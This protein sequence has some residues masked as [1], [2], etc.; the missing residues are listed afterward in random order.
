[1]EEF[2]KL[3][4]AAI[5]TIDILL[6]FT[7]EKMKTQIRLSPGS[8]VAI[9]RYLKENYSTRV[10]EG[11]RQNVKRIKGVVVKTGLMNLWIFSCHLQSPWI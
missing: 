3:V 2:K 7:E 6:K 5:F 8:V 1:M 4:H 9:K 11:P 10:K